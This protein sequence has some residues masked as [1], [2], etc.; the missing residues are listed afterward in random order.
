MAEDGYQ[1][2]QGGQRKSVKMN[3][4]PFDKLKA[5][6]YVEGHPTFNFQRS[7]K[8][9]IYPEIKRWKAEEKT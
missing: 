8:S 7:M 3:V 4:Q 1:M 2:G 9:R 6:S 5:L